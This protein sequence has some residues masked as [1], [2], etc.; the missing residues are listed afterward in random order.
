MMEMLGRFRT[1]LVPPTTESKVR[2]D[3]H[4]YAV[5]FSQ[6][7]PLS[8]HKDIVKAVEALKSIRPCKSDEWIPKEGTRHYELLTKNG[9]IS[10]IAIP[11]IDKDPS[12][13]PEIVIETEPFLPDGEF[14]DE[15]TR[16]IKKIIDMTGFKAFFW[17]SMKFM[18]PEE[19]RE[20][21][22]KLAKQ[23]KAVTLKIS[24]LVNTPSRASKK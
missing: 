7:S 15:I 12:G 4:G 21:Q 17:G 2:K 20:W 10:I 18:S 24:K 5:S 9:V 6:D 16:L 14:L 3:K 13:H 1:T 11:H 8:V 22:E 23:E 19:I